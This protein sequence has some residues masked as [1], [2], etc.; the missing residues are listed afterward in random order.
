MK[1]EKNEVKKTVRVKNLYDKNYSEN[2][3]KVNCNIFFKID[4][5]KF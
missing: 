3:E 1:N 4:E 2:K 5:L